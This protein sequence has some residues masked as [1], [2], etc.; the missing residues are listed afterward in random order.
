MKDVG[1]MSQYPVVL[2]TYHIVAL[3]CDSE[4]DLFQES[5]LN[6]IFWNRVILDEAH[7]IKNPKTNAATGVCAINTHKR[8][9]VTGTPVHNSGK[10]FYSLMKFLRCSPFDD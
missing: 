9:V 1:R 7:F 5:P 2:T 10:D 3:E 8:W 4:N 6:K